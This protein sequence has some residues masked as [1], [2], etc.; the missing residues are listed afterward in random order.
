MISTVIRTIVLY[1]TVTIAIRLMG[2]RQIGDMQPNELVVTLLISEIAAIPL[3]DSDQPVIIGIAAIFV[4]VFLEIIISILTLKSFFVRKILN[5]KSVVIIKNG[6][7]DQKAMRDV[8]MTVVDLIE[9]LR[10]KDVFKI[11]DVAFAVLEVNGNLSVLLKKDAQTVTISDIE[12][13]LPDDALPLPVISDGKIVDE[14]LKALQVSRQK[15]FKIIKHKKYGVKQI[16]LMTLDRNG[17]HTIIE[18]GGAN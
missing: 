18:K 8:R 5:G 16:F 10:S 15:L 4:L 1:A 2:K 17:N 14:S 12:L 13:K 9:L 11:S 7:I 6:I 3:Q